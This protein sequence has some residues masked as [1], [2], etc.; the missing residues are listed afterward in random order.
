MI[1][2]INILAAMLLLLPALGWAEGT[3]DADTVKKA[4]AYY[5]EGKDIVLVDYKFCTLIN[6]EGENKNNCAE[7]VDGKTIVKGNKVYLWMNFFVPGDDTKK[8]KTLVQFSRKGKVMVSKTL[9]VSQSIRY[10][11]WRQMPTKTVGDW[12]IAI[13]QEGEEAFSNI[14]NLDYTVVDAPEE[15]AV[16]Q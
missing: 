11:T 15:T 4:L 9:S 7:V 2:R 5:H 14:A 16:A 12:K 8:V 10:R 6:K 1:K 3:S 13:E